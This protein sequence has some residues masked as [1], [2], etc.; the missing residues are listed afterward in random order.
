MF[1]SF[2]VGQN[3]RIVVMWGQYPC[4]LFGKRGQIFPIDLILKYSHL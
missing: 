4:V 1:L 3:C 2:H